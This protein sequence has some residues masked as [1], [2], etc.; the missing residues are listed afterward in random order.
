MVAVGHIRGKFEVAVVLGVLE[1]HWSLNLRCLNMFSSMSRHLEEHMRA[2]FLRSIISAH[3]GWASL[4]A[5]EKLR[6]HAAEFT[7]SHFQVVYTEN[8]SLHTKETKGIG[9]QL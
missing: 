9:T 8:F 7:Q 1:Y 2:T 4:I 5:R 3:M 6:L